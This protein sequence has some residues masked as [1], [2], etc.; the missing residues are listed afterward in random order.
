MKLWKEKGKPSGPDFVMGEKKKERK[1]LKD[2][3]PEN[4]LSGTGGRLICG[5]TPRRRRHLTEQNVS[6]IVY[7]IP[8][9]EGGEGGRRWGV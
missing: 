8:A 7:L 1:D 3:S 9:R 4:F 5:K 6:V 2:G